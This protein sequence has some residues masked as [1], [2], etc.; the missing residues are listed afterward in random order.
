MFADLWMLDSRGEFTGVLQGAL[1]KFR[2]LGYVIMKLNDAF[3]IV[4]APC[5]KTI[6]CCYGR[7]L[8]D[9][10]I[11]SLDVFPLVVAAPLS[12]RDFEW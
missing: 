7:I 6:L 1:W 9:L 8:Y 11:R 4:L 3:F 10:V 12:P 5:H 2:G